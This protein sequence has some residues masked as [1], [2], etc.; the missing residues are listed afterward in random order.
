MTSFPQAIRIAVVPSLGTNSAYS[1]I[2]R[3]D[4]PLWP[5]TRACNRGFV[6]PV[7]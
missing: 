3:R 7:G 2:A 5:R 1:L 6:N 4:Y